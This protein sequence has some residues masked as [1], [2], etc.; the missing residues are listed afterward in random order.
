MRVEAF[1]L[2]D[3]ATVQGGKLNVLGAFDTVYFSTVPAVYPACSIALRIRWERI[4]EGDH[5]LRITI[6]DADGKQ[7]GPPV[8]GSA[9]VRMPTGA[10]TAVSN[11]TLQMQRLP[12]KDYGE[13]SIDLAIDGRQ[14]GSLPLIVK[15]VRPPN[16]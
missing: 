15:P 3:A 12:F 7:L 8:Q 14:E 4:E 10:S 1:M 6:V 9:R 13:F 5:S 11:L 16:S 2:C